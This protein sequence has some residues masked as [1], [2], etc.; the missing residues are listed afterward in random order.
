[1]PRKRSKDNQGL[2]NRWRIKHGAYYYRVPP[3]EE[4]NWNGKQD[5]RLG[6]TLH[7]AHSTFAKHIK[8]YEHASTMAE[9]LDRYALEVVPLKAPAT[10]RGNVMSLETLRRIFGDNKISAIKPKH[11]YQFR[12]YRSKTSVVGAN[13]DL[14]VLSHAFTKA[15][16]W[17][18]IDEH[19]MK[20]KVLKN[21]VRPRKRYV[22]D[23]ELI[24]ALSVASPFLRSY[25]R[26]KLLLGLRKGDMLRIKLADLKKDGIHVHQSKTGKSVIYEWTPAV[27]EAI[28]EIKAQTGPVASIYLF[29]TRRGQPYIKEDGTTSGFD[30]IWQRFMKKALAETGLSERFTEH[31]LRAKAAS[32]TTAEHAKELLGHSSQAVTERVYLRKPKQIRPVDS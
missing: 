12:D 2:P 30:S 24:E 16:E 17:G 21:P 14:E 9:L 5:F 25:V 15:I 7:E 32:D 6:K 31:D 13:R 20:G 27:R 28:E 11:C 26:L 19:P 29:S 3:G 18:L 22:S 10:Q 1:M 8:Q 4:S 23:Q